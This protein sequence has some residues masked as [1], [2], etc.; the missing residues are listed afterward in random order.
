MVSICWGLIPDNR[1]IFQGHPTGVHNHL[2]ALKLMKSPSYLYVYYD[3]T[4]SENKGWQ[5]LIVLT[6]YTLWCMYH[7]DNI[8]IARQNG[9]HFCMWHVH[10]RQWKLLDFDSM[11]SIDACARHVFKTWWY[12][13]DINFSSKMFSS[14]TTNLI[15]KIWFAITNNVYA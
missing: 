9:H 7:I 6:L 13:I 14:I 5:H 12:L 15:F 3:S 10:F 1:H 11:L 4:K 8:L 2:T